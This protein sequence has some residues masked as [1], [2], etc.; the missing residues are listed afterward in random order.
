MPKVVQGKGIYRT[1]FQGDPLA[2]QY[3]DNKWSVRNNPCPETPALAL[4]PGTTV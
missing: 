1:K 3:I 2:F 4:L